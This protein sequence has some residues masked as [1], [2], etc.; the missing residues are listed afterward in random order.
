MNYLITN[1][2]VAIRKGEFVKADEQAGEFIYDSTTT[3]KKQY[4]IGT[5]V[6]IA[7]ANKIE[8]DENA[9]KADIIL[10][11]NDGLEALKL[12]EQNK[13]SDT[14]AVKQIVQAGHEAGTSE[15][16]MLVQIVQSG[17]KFG[18]A[19]KMMKQAQEDLGLALSPKA[20]YEKS[21]G[22]MEGAGFSPETHE[23]VANMASVLTNEVQDTNEKQALAA[24]RKYCK[25]IEVELP[26]KPKAE[27]TTGWAGIH[28][29]VYEH[30]LANPDTTDDALREFLESIGKVDGEK[31]KFVKRYK[32]IVE[33]VRKARNGDAD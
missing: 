25:E 19:M 28:T 30:I 32:P 4:P 31:D 2:F 21:H 6:E 11:L 12:P 17:V 3:E 8:V 23:D 14:D 13:M 27:K 1:G 24:I 18:N 33:L 20:R 26:K 7:S 10:A 16:E 15:D 9:K 5:L 29:K 22:I